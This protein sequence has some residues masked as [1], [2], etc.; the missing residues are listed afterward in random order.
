MFERLISGT[1]L[2]LGDIKAIL[3]RVAGHK[4]NTVLQ[5][6]KLELIIGTDHYDGAPFSQHRNIVW[7]AIR[8]VWPAVR[9][10][11]ALTNITL[12]PQQCIMEFLTQVQERWN[13]E[14]MEPR[15]S[16][17]GSTILFTTMIRKCLPSSGQTG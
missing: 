10:L 11:T 7:D 8:E 16:T 1:S 4:A 6:A 3:A 5:N 14:V 17:A 15:D 13:Q 2:C 12:G 9:D